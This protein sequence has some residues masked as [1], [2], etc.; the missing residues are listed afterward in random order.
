MKNVSLDPMR[1]N[2]V[3]AWLH[4]DASSCLL[5]LPDEVELPERFAA[6]VGIPSERIEYLAS[7]EIRPC[8]EPHPDVVRALETSDVTDVVVVVATS[9]RQFRG[10]G[11]RRRAIEFL[12]QQFER[13]ENYHLHP[14]LEHVSQMMIH[15]WL[16]DCERSELI[17][18]DPLA[19]ELDP[20]RRISLTPQP[21]EPAGSATYLDS[22]AS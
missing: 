15:G 3:Q 9:C 17:A 8:F 6:C 12:V 13:L 22:I 14:R 16:W 2:I 1:R 5:L 20:D 4:G 7:G 18:L 19:G 21:L 10:R 11:R